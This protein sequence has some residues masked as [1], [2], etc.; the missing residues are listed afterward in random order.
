MIEF[1]ANGD[2]LFLLHRIDYKTDDPKL[3]LGW[4]D[5]SPNK[6]VAKG[7]SHSLP[8]LELI[9]E[10]VPE[11]EKLIRVESNYLT[12]KKD[13]REVVEFANYVGPNFF[14]SFS[15]T[16]LYGQP[17]TALS[18][19]KNAVITDEMAMTLF[20][21]VDVVGETFWIGSNQTNVY[22]ISGVIKKP[23]NSSLKPSVILNLENS[24]YFK[25]NQ[26]NWR[27]SAI[28]SFLLLDDPSSA[29][30]VSKKISDIYAER[31]SDEISSQREALK[32][33]ENNPVVQYG[34]KNIQGLYLDPSINYR[35]A[36]LHF[37]QLFLSVSAYSFY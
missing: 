16:F 30:L 36:H 29:S 35:R 24:Y 10:R 11:V 8:F 20:G 22:L 32:L 21:K 33:S 7:I 4:F 5:S 26:D 13:D 25:E 3:E 23:V 17:S 1:H 28:S 37:I 19:L 2:K 31:F 34:L 15:F 27:Y 18:E 12:I 6:G 14:E 9:E